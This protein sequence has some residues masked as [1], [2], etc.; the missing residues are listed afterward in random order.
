MEKI[1]LEPKA[2]G[3]WLLYDV[4]HNE[5]KV[6]CFYAIK[7][8]KS[9]KSKSTEINIRCKMCRSHPRLKYVIKENR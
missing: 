4:V 2:G 1:L 5:P 7:S 9:K 8:L 6:Y 3:H